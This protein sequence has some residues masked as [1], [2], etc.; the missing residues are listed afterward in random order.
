M[1]NLPITTKVLEEGQDLENTEMVLH[2]EFVRVCIS[3]GKISSELVDKGLIIMNWWIK[4][5]YQP[6]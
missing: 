4:P 5:V 3:G 1:T 6:S 2:T